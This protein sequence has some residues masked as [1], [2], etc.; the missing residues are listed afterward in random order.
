MRLPEPGD[1]AVEDE[2]PIDPHGVEN[3]A[4]DRLGEVALDQVF[5]AQEI[6]IGAGLPIAGLGLDGPGRGLAVGGGL[7]AADGRAELIKPAELAQ[8]GPEHAV[9]LREAARIVSLHI[10]DVAVL[11]AHLLS[12]D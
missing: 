6:V 10:D 5:P 7:Q 9:V 11:N 3:R 8:F 1:R 12:P 4:P 2:T